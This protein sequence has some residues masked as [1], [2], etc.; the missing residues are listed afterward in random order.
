MTHRLAHG[1]ARLRSSQAT[2][3]RRRGQVSSPLHT[4]NFGQLRAARQRE[5]RE[6]HPAYPRPEGDDRCGLGCALRH[7]HQAPQRAGGAQ[8]EPLPGRFHVLT[9][10]GREGG[11]GRKLRPPCQAQVLTNA[12]VGF[13]RARRA[14][15]G[16]QAQYDPRGRGERLYRARLRA[17]A[18]A[19]RLEHGPPPQAR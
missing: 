11:G 8:R 13:H 17:A 7:E 5:Y 14:D 1:G 15:G 3:A 18:R 12:A 4:Q 16:F 9:Y 2:P 19:H 10:R 6:P